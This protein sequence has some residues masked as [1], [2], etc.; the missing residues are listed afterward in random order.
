MVVTPAG[1]PSDHPWRLP[2]RT[3][4][5]AAWVDPTI[6]SVPGRGLQFD[7]DSERSVLT[8]D[9]PVR[10]TLLVQT[11][12]DTKAVVHITVDCF[13][14]EGRPIPPMVRGSKGHEFPPGTDLDGVRLGITELT[15][16]PRDDAGDPITMPYSMVKLPLKTL[17][18]DALTQV[19]FVTDGSHPTLAHVSRFIDGTTRPKQARV[20]RWERAAL[21]YLSAKRDGRPTADAVLAELPDL[22]FVKKTSK[23]GRRQKGDRNDKSAALAAARMQIARLK[24]LDDGEFWHEMEAKFTAQRERQP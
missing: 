23:D 24:E 2:P 3:R 22:W 1:D 10:V 20:E 9:L 14:R 13:D 15:V 5:V 19:C 16:D 4:Q 21:A 17:L 7:L 18:K 11:T 12:S 8:A 6:A